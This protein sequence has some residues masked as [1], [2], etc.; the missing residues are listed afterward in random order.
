MTT[1]A[2]AGFSNPPNVARPKPSHPRRRFSPLARTRSGLVASHLS[3]RTGSGTGH[4]CAPVSPPGVIGAAVI[5]AARRSAGLTRHGLA[6]RLTISTAT[7]RS[8]ENGSVP[9]YCVDYGQLGH[10]ADILNHAGAKVGCELA[11]LVLASQC[12]LLITGMLQGFEDYAEVPPIDEHTTDGGAARGLL[13]WALNGRVPEPYHPYAPPQ[14]LLTGPD[15]A[16]IAWI[17]RDLRAGSDRGQLA[18]F[19]QALADLVDP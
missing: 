2:I 8:W 11:E 5:K 4:A 13:R 15:P 7:V 12:D 3:G 10:L 16:R 14:P 19:G 9:L 18:S 1:T 17:A 6:R